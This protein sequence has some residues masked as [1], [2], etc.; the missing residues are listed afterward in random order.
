MGF[1]SR[2]LSRATRAAF[3][4]D[5]DQYRAFAIGRSPDIVPSDGGQ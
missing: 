4:Q 5:C 3:F 1:L 2:D